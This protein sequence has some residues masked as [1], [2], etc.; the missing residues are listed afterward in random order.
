MYQTRPQR[1]VTM[2]FS[3]LNILPLCCHSV[4]CLFIS[5]HSIAALSSCGRSLP[6]E[7]LCVLFKPNH[8]SKLSIQEGIVYFVQDKQ[9]FD[10]V[11][12]RGHNISLSR[13]NSTLTCE[14]VEGIIYY[15]PDQYNG[16]ITVLLKWVNLKCYQQRHIDQHSISDLSACQVRDI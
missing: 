7:N 13:T 2:H 4:L 1:V 8:T 14:Y 6:L 10:L 3:S 12:P 15:V 5:P 16:L 11:L 9:H